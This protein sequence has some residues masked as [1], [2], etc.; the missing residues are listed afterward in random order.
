M[1]SDAAWLSAT[2]QGGY[3]QV[4]VDPAGLEGSVF[5]GTITLSVVGRDDIPPITL[6]VTVLIGQLDVLLPDKLY[7][8][9]V[10]RR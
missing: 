5:T 3:L 6:P 10:L 1:V 8:P 9:V 4:H 2:V 7:I